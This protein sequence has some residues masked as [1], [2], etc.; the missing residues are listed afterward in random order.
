MTFSLSLVLSCTLDFYF[1]K[2]TRFKT[3]CVTYI[4][5]KVTSFTYFYVFLITWYFL[6]CILILTANRSSIRTLG[7]RSIHILD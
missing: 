3:E 7:N 6:V 4:I 2:F 1:A 5:L